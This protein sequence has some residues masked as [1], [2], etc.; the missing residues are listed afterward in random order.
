M[1]PNKE[2]DL[3]CLPPGDICQLTETF[4][5]VITGSGVLTASSGERPG[6]ILNFLHCTGQPGTIKNDLASNAKAAKDE[7]AG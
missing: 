6:M 7:K 4:L 2:S 5:V 3:V 1:V